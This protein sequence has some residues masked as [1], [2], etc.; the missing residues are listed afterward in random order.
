MQ[1]VKRL[2]TVGLV[3]DVHYAD[4]RPRINRY[5]RES[6]TKLE[7]AARVLRELKVDVAV[8]LGDLIDVG[9]QN[10]TEKELAFLKRIDQVFAGMADERHY[11]LGNHCVATLKKSEFLAAV[12]KKRSY[13]A[14]SRNRVKLIFLDACFRADG[15]AYGEGPFRWSDC[16]IPR[17]QRTWLE[18]ELKCARGPVVVFVHQR[19][20]TPLE[21]P[22]TIKS[23]VE[24]RRLLE[25]SKKVRVVVMGHSH[26]N[27]LTELNG[28]SYLTLAALVEGSGLENGGYSALKIFSD[29]SFELEGF[30]KHAQHP[31]HGKH[32]NLVGVGSK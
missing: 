31:A 18:K 19:L 15:V 9:F 13:Y 26:C 1:G 11:V 4:A 24:V 29:G 12:G 20:D 2:L 8:E 30:R 25:E 14:V 23:A 16:E 22:Y 3:T 28:I 32:L 7:E 6:L 21:S 17:E 5:Y 27:V 10:S